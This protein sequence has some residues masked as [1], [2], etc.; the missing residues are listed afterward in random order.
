V[1][2]NGLIAPVLILLALLSILPPVDA[3]TIS[4]ISQTARLKQVL[5]ENNM[6]SGNVITP[7]DKIPEEAKQTIRESMSYLER[8]RY[9]D[10]IEWLP[11]YTSSEFSNI[12]GFSSNLYVGKSEYKNIYLYLKQG[13]PVDIAGYDYILDTNIGKDGAN[14]EIGTF[15]KDGRSFT[16]SYQQEGEKTYLLLFEQK[17]ELLRFPVDDIFDRY[18]DSNGNGIE[19]TPEEARF[20]AQNNVAILTLVTKMININSWQDGINKRAEAYILIKIK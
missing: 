6:L 3:F 8:L 10:R 13:T 11:D 4:R 7:N 19:L 5:T 17:T 20:S 9:L 14:S 18:A 2:K 1:R 16:L 15:E 12:F